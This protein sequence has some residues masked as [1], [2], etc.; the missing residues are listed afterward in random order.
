MGKRLLGLYDQLIHLVGSSFPFHPTAIYGLFLCS[1]RKE[2]S[3]PVLSRVQP[4]TVLL[5]HQCYCCRNAAHLF[6]D[7]KE[8]L[9]LLCIS[10]QITTGTSSSFPTSSFPTHLC[11]PPLNTG[12]LQTPISIINSNTLLHQGGNVSAPSRSLSGSFPA[13][14]RLLQATN[15]L[16][17]K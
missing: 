12:L 15:S 10:L 13:R 11:P 6:G 7:E 1:N 4:C 16:K 14:I 9:L 17:L 8:Q 2:Q 3:S 5:L